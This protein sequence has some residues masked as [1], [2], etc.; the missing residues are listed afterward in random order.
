[1][2]SKNLLFTKEDHAKLVEIGLL[3]SKGDSYHKCAKS[4][5]LVITRRIDALEWKHIKYKTSIKYEAFLY[6]FQ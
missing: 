2:E 3:K 5:N 1:M 4:K 6:V